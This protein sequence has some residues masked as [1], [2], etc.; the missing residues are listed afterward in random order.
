MSGT[1]VEAARSMTNLFR[2]ADLVGKGCMVMLK[3]NQAPEVR[4]GAAQQ[5]RGPSFIRGS[6]SSVCRR[7]AFLRAFTPGFFRPRSNQCNAWQ[8]LTGLLLRSFRKY[9]G[10]PWV[11]APGPFGTRML[12]LA[13]TLRKGPGFPRRSISSGTAPT[14]PLKGRSYRL[15]CARL[16]PTVGALHLEASGRVHPV[17]LEA[18]PPRRGFPAPS[19]PNGSPLRPENH[20]PC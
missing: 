16:G 15:Y 6:V 8:G 11:S 3:A 12:K 19:R 1:P 18:M 20:Y 14:G 13:F 17:G 4:H 9:A 7:I 2:S 5:R 10:G